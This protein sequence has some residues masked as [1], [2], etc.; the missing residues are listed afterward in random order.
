MAYVLSTFIRIKSR[1]KLLIGTS[2]INYDIEIANCDRYDLPQVIN[3]T[4][5]GQ[6]FFTLCGRTNV[7]FDM[8][9]M[10]CDLLV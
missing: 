4:K 7:N 6:F 5:N 10:I 3:H 9:K 8:W 2:L 1:L